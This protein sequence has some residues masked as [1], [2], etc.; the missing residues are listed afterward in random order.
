MDSVRSLTRAQCARYALLVVY[1]WDMCD[2]A[3]D[4]ASDAIDPRIKADGWTVVGLITGADDVPAEF[5][6]KRRT[7][8]LVRA[9]YEIDDRQRNAALKI[10]QTMANR[11]E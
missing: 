8:E 4:P 2:A 5:V 3:L 11:A 1:A 10:L 9:F 7:V 6:R